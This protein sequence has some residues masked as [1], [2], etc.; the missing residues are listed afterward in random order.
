MAE[1]SII[2]PVYNSSKYL[3]KCFE[4]IMIQTYNDFEVIVINDGSTDNSG[5]ICDKYALLDTRFKVIHKKNEGVSIARNTGIEQ[6][7]G[8]YITFIDSDDWIDEDYLQNLYNES[9]NKADLVV[10]GIICEYNDNSQ[11]ILNISDKFFS[12]REA[13]WLHKLVK[14]R[15]LFGPCNKLYKTS[16]IKGYKLSFP[17]NISYGEDR[18][19][20]YEYL[21]Y[22]S[23]IRTISYSGYHYRQ[24]SGN[25]LTT[26]SRT[27]MF[28]L[29]YSQ[30]QLLNEAYK[31]K[32]A[33][34]QEVQQDQYIE[35]FWIIHDNIFAN[36]KIGRSSF[37]A[38]IT[39]VLSIPEISG[40]R[41]Y[42]ELISYNRVIKYSILNRC[43]GLL[44]LYIQL[45][46]LCKK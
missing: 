46:N 32:E 45:L 36:R 7:C 8:K 29:E 10:S 38:Y 27:N 35:L 40:I 37:Y 25:S 4:S 11:R 2:V 16:I 22:V 33:F 12:S 42:A 18:I 28:E 43:S 24:S 21:K 26:I 5:N 20:N 41:P 17:L 13:S 39:K 31:N 23:T 44:Y 14:S 30:W 6:S 3:E 15:L 19:F 34:N 1:I 9:Y